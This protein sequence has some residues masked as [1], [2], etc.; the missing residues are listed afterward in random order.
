MIYLV[1]WIQNYSL[2]QRTQ[3]NNFCF[4][5][6]TA[7]CLWLY[8]IYQDQALL[9]LLHFLQCCVSRNRS[10]L[11]LGVGVSGSQCTRQA[12]RWFIRILYYH[13]TV[14]W[15]KHRQNKSSRMM[16]ECKKKQAD[17]L[18]S[19]A[20]FLLPSLNSIIYYLFNKLSLGLVK[21]VQQESNFL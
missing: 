19:H 12:R 8:W 11:L 2:T 13:A 6:I 15:Y 4:S 3:L 1:M 14:L 10:G 17:L 18:L 5:A 9:Q 20:V 7:I 16:V 21:G